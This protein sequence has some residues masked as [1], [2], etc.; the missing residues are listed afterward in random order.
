MTTETYRNRSQV[1][2]NTFSRG[3][4]NRKALEMTNFAESLLDGAVE[5]G[6]YY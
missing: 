5:A 6:R 2:G 3:N 4:S 1:E